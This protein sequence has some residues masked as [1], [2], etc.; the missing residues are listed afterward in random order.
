MAAKVNI[1]MLPK[2]TMADT[3][4]VTQEGRDGREANLSSLAK[5]IARTI[6]EHT[7]T[8]NS[9]LAVSTRTI[10]FTEKTVYPDFIAGLYPGL[11]IDI[12]LTK[13]RLFIMVGDV[14]QAEYVISSGKRGTPT[15]SG[16]F[17]IKNKLALAQS[18]LFPGI[19]M[20][21]WNALARTPDGGGYQGYGLHRVPCFDARCYSRE[22]A[23]H[24]GRPVSHGCVR[25]EDAGADWVYNNAPVGTPVNIHT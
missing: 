25:I 10:P 20:E 23:S 3:Q 18:R 5:E 13:Q 9:P 15:P 12:N 6:T 2:T 24:L 21:N 16:V 22:P 17:Y 4:Q 14:K 8:A 19:W 7:D 1:K 11:Y